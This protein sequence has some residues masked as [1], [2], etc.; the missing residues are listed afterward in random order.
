MSGVVSV[1]VGG[2][3]RL[4]R[5]PPSLFGT[6]WIRVWYGRKLGEKKMWSEVCE[7]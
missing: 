3:L 4:R 1:V 2:L 7:G 6:S 5:S